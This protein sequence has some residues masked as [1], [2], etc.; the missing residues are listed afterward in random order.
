M[1]CAAA[2]SFDLCT[3]AFDLQRDF[4]AKESLLWIEAEL[5]EETLAQT[6]IPLRERYNV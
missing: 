5:N 4:E 1:G 6:A 3:A 2:Q